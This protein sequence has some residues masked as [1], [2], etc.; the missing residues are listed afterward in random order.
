MFDKIKITKGF[1]SDI[2][3]QK[4]EYLLEVKRIEKM[5]LQELEQILYESMN[6]KI[7][8][9]DNTITSI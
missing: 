9:Q 5:I 4:Q 3:K 2:Q 6:K 1:L 8:K 7:L